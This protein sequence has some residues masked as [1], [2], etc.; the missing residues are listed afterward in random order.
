[1]A[2]IFPASYGY[3]CVLGIKAEFRKTS[4]FCIVAIWTATLA[5]C[6]ETKVYLAALYLNRA[7]QN[8]ERS[9]SK[10]FSIILK[11][12]QKVYIFKILEQLIIPVIFKSKI[13]V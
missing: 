3:S 2:S 11:S 8:R 5:S 10:I 13:Q 6:R 7:V 12:F 1:M 9:T 4:T